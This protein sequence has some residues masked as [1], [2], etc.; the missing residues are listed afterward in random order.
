[1]ARFFGN[2]GFVHTVDKGNGV[3]KEE[4]TERE[5]FGDVNIPARRLETATRINNDVEARNTIDVVVDDYAAEN[6]FAIRYV[7]WKGVRWIVTYVEDQ[8]PRL[9][10]TL[11][12]VYNGPKVPAPDTP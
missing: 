4:P 12:G 2:V 6:M 3:F 1:M 9:I 10:L 11:G 5:L 7:W 8:R